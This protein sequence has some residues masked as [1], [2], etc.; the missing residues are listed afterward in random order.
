MFAGNVG[1]STVFTEGFEGDTSQ[2][3][4]SFGTYGTGSNWSGSDH[5]QIPSGGATYANLISGQGSGVDGGAI[6]TTAF[7]LSGLL[8]ASELSAVAA[9]TATWGFNSW[10]AG[11]QDEYTSFDIEWFD[12]AGGTG[13]SLGAQELVPGETAI[14]AVSVINGATL[15][16][17]SAN[18]NSLNWSNYETTGTVAAGAVSFVITYNGN[19]LTGAQNAGQGTNDGYS[20]NLNLTITT[21]PEPSSAALLGLG[22]LALILRRRK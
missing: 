6:A 17:G 18:W 10:L 4:N 7:D 22:G 12:G 21:V 13:S 8:S 5:G 15:E 1:A 19:D 14:N 20:D 2:W 3:A 9:G 16:A 11:Y